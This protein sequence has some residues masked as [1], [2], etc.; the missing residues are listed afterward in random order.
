MNSK[1]KLC[2][3]YGSKDSPKYSNHPEEFLRITLNDIRKMADDPQDVS[4]EKAQWIIPSTLPSRVNAEQRERGDRHALIFDKDKNPEIDLGQLA[5]NIANAGILLCEYV[6]YTT[7]GAT[8]DNQKIRIIAELQEPVS[9]EMGEILQIIFNNRMEA[10]GITPDR[11]TERG[12]QISYLPN[13]GE[14]YDSQ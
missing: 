11:S 7:K 10:I 3:G 13:R 12:N 14:F 9:G 8:K 1:V 4:K 5:F 6:M 2:S